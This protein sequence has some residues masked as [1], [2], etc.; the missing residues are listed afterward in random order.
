[1][2][3]SIRFLFSM[4]TLVAVEC[5]ILSITPPQVFYPALIA[6]IF[7]GPGFALMVHSLLLDRNAARR[8]TK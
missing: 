5:F 6:A 3:Y 8:K 7:V 4:V 1:M 2:R